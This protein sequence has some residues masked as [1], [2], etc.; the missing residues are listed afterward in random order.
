MYVSISL[1]SLAHSLHWHLRAKKSFIL[2]TAIFPPCKPVSGRV[3]I[4]YRNAVWVSNLSDDLLCIRP[5]AGPSRRCIQE[6]VISQQQGHRPQTRTGAAWSAGAVLPVANPIL[7]TILCFMWALLVGIL[8]MIMGS[9][10][11]WVP[12]SYIELY[13]LSNLR[14]ILWG[15]LLNSFVCLLA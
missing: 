9:G 13:Q 1:F 5:W 14:F 3:A 15:V 4:Q 8:G 10:Q 11:M 7:S 12:I 6:E 2:L